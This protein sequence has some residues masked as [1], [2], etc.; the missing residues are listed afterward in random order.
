[1]DKKQLNDSLASI[2]NSSADR[3]ILPGKSFYQETL[4]QTFNKLLRVFH[5]NFQT[6]FSCMNMMERGESEKISTNQTVGHL[7]IKPIFLKC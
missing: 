7:Q 1:M 6:N 3:I 5:F 4:K 2:K